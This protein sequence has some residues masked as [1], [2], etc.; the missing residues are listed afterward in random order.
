MPLQTATNPQT[1]ETVV[2]VDGAW[3]K[4]EQV[5]T[6]PK[7]QS[8][9]YLVGGTWITD[10]TRTSTTPASK[11][12]LEGDL[13]KLG[14]AE[15]GVAETTA[16][17]GTGIVAT[18]AAGLAG[19]AQGVANLG[20]PIKTRIPGQP[21]RT[22][23]QTSAAD[24]VA[25]VQ[26]SLTYQPR[27]AE[28]QQMTGAAAEGLSY[29]S[30]KPGQFVGSHA[31]ELATKMG[32]SPELA[33][34]IGAGADTAVE[35]IPQALLAKG[36]GAG[37]TALR[38]GAAGAEAGA[39]A[40]AAGAARG[41]AGAAP[42]A[43]EAATDAAGRA[44]AY[45]GNL[46]L[47]W[48]KLSVAF[49]DKLTG[50][51]QDAQALGKLKPEQVKRQALLA[52]V[53]IDTPSKGQ[54]TRDPIQKGLEADVKNTGAGKPLL[55]R[56]YEHNRI[57]QGNVERLRQKVTAESVR[58]KEGVARGD[59]P[60]GRAVQDTALRAK[61]KASKANYDR[62]YKI[63]RK[64][65]PDAAVPVDSLYDLLG[66]NPHIQHL[67]WV[68]SWLKRA[69]IETEEPAAGEKGETDGGSPAGPT[70]RPVTL[71]ELNDLRQ[72]ANGIIKGG[73]TDAHYAAQVKETIDAAMEAVPESAK[74]W[75][76]AINAYR[77]HSQ[78]FKDQGAVRGLVEDK[79]HSSDRRLAIEETAKK[80]VTG[81][82]EDLQK[83]KRSLLTGEDATARAAG[84]LAW[85]DLKG[86][87]LDYIRARMTRGP[88]NEVGDPHATWVGI[89]TALDDI[90]D[91]NLD[92]LY[93]PTV[94]KQ[95]RRYQDAAEELWTEPSTRQTGSP[96]FGRILRFLDRVG[97][98]P[99]L[100]T[101]SD[102]AAGVVKGA[103]KVSE[104][105]EGGRTTRAAMQTPLDEALT[106]TRRAVRKSQTLGTLKRYGQASKP[107]APTV[108]A[109]EQRQEP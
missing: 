107:L 17:L 20:G 31:Q 55:E 38:G 21:F 60:V 36:A 14:R 62:L 53:G 47:D 82:L 51:A 66:N 104:I 44:K 50:I 101:A 37:V 56:D 27:T 54:V 64:T 69:K 79:P 68:N 105:G 86:W 33:G 103:Q 99:G 57:L 74:A 26:S 16:A 4:A 93:G 10:E 78:E 2:L 41:A 98:V 83:V 65:E 30:S 52:E 90:G 1:N 45:V 59:L 24:R 15:V 73:G 39:E 42:G 109:A 61:A 81:K 84:K 100:G 34:A 89:K 18:P 9:A 67:G 58:G 48:D 43:A 32:A 102:Y 12:G 19:I 75:K 11:P 71:N 70:R 77:R 87:G 92:E 96:T 46:G 85:R 88:K 35:I 106:S 91:A 7:D 25:Q 6:N 5:A 28:G 76:A 13:Q 97:G 80:T 29:L 3:Q 63:A 95:L 49:K 40:G 94:R 72:E 23:P 8:K 108:P 22:L